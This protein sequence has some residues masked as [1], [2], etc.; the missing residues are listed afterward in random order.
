MS[1]KPLEELID[2][3][4]TPEFLEEQYIE[5]LKTHELNIRMCSDKYWR[6]WEH[7]TSLDLVWLDMKDHSKKFRDTTAKYIAQE[8]DSAL[9]LIDPKHW[10]EKRKNFMDISV[11]NTKDLVLALEH[12]NNAFTTLLNKGKEM[13]CKIIKRKGSSILICLMD[14]ER[15]YCAVK[16]LKHI[17][18]SEQT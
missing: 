16:G 5:W 12:L 7:I 17:V 10:S 1:S 13:D 3:Y 9:L 14:L 2:K 18:R 15:L 6:L 8:I 4:Y 11:K